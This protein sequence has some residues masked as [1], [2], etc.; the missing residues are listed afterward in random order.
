[1]SII[2]DEREQGPSWARANWPLVELDEVNAGLDPTLGALPEVAA[3][4]KADAAI[5]GKSEAEI[6][7]AANDAICA[8]M[9]IRTY[10]VRGHLAANLDP[11]GLSKRDMPADLTPEYHGFGPDALD[12]P[13]F[14][15]GALGLHQATVRELV[16]I[17]RRNYCGNVGLEYMHINAVEE[18][19]FLQ[20]RMEGREAEIRFTPEGKRSILAKVIQAEQWEKFLARKYVGTK[21][22]GLDGGESMVPALEAVIKYGGQYG[23]GEIDVGMAHRGRLNI[24]SNVMGKPAKAIFHE[25]AGGATNP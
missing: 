4:A 18:R 17:L 7:R 19:R 16:E 15:G 23:V 24:L 5:A 21:R 25:F 10:R 14:L 3:R 2:S 8:M 6:E 11:L 1:M 20:E 13:V 9:L 12:R 22:F